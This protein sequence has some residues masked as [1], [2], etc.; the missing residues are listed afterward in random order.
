MAHN[1][2][3]DGALRDRVLIEGDKGWHGLGEDRK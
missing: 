1:I 2:V 3:T